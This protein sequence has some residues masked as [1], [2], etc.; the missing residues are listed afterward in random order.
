MKNYKLNKKITKGQIKKFVIKYNF[1][2]TKKLY[3]KIC[4]MIKLYYLSFEHTHIIYY[5][6]DKLIII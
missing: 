4:I 1:N 6:K 5:Y 2:P 3:E